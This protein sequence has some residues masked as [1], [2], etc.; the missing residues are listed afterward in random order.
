ML[1]ARVPSAWV[2]LLVWHHVDTVALPLVQL[3]EA[4]VTTAIW[5]FL[6]TKTIHFLIHPVASVLL[7]IWPPVGAKAFNDSIFVGASVGLTIRPLL[8]TVSLSFVIGVG[9]KELCTIRVSF[10]T[11][12]LHDT[13]SELTFVDEEVYVSGD[14]LAMVHVASPLSLISLTLN[15]SEFAKAM[16]VSQIPSSFIDWTVLKVHGTTSVAE[17]TQP[18]A[19][20]CGTWRSV[21]MHAHLK[22]QFFTTLSQ[23]L[24]FD[25]TAPW[26]SFHRVTDQECCTL[27]SVGIP[28][29]IVAH[30]SNFSSPVSLNFDNPVHIWVQVITKFMSSIAAWCQLIINL[31]R[32]STAKVFEWICELLSHLS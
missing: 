30:T 13:L 8:N 32:L 23:R 24:K 2:C 12:A 15:L 6:H 19:I 1:L 11:D 22:L 27:L 25:N 17:T 10:F 26:D 18:L 14:T 29:F 7:S 16:T 3:V 21:A 5:I 4:F 28:D 9:A 31:H 20:I